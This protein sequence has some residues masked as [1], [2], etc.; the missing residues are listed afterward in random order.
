VANRIKNVARGSFHFVWDFTRYVKTFGHGER[1]G[2]I[3]TR[4]Q[5]DQHFTVLLIFWCKKI[6]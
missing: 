5:F 4:R 1:L 6:P 2:V 3:D